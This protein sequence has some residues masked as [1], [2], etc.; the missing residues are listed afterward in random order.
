M[1]KKITVRTVGIALAIAIVAV[2]IYVADWHQIGCSL[3]GADARFVFLSVPFLVGTFVVFAARWGQLIALESPPPMRDLFSFL[4]I[5]YL[6]NAILPARPGDVVRAVLL[7]QRFQVNISY[8]IASLVLERVV[9]LSAVCALGIILSSMIPIPPLLL[10]AIY[11]V[12]AL[13]FGFLAV[14]ILVSRQRGALSRFV[15]AHP[16]AFQ[17]RFLCVVADLLGRF[18]LGI[19][20]ASSP[21]RMAVSVA[22]TALGWTLMAVYMMSMIKAFHLPVPP[23]A[24]L[25]VLIGTNLGALMPLSPGA[26]GVWHFMAVLSLA[27]WGIDNSTSIAFAIAAHAIAIGL[28]VGLGIACA[29]YEGIRVGSLTSL[30]QTKDAA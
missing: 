11:T 9:D 3:S 19:D 6:A 13:V 20:I 15:E 27:L 1:L 18:V 16:V 10:S 21:R 30:S 14:L 8:G 26:V 17:N 4:M 12:S 7:R 2:G 5:G 25:L 23:A 29:M 28:H 22:L 24:A